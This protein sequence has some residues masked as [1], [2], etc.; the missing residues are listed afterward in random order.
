MEAFP[1]KLCVMP[2]HAKNPGRP[3]FFPIARLAMALLWALS[4]RSAAGQ[5]ITN[6]DQ[7]TRV[8]ASEHRAHRSLQ[9]EVTVC[10]ASRPKVGVLIVQ[11]KTGVELLAVGNFEREILPGEKILI[12]GEYDLLRQREMGVELA[13]AP[14]VD[15]DG[16][17]IRRTLVAST[18]LKA[19]LIPLRLDWF[20]GLR[21]FNLEVACV[22]SN[23]LG[24]NI[25]AS[26]LWHA[27]V[28][29][30]G[31]TNFSP[32]LLAE[33]YEGYWEAVPD[34][35]LLQPV[36]RGVVSNFD[37]GFKPRD[38][39]VGVRFTGC[40]N[41]PQDGQYKF[42]VR[43]KDGSLLFLNAPE[44][45]PVRLGA[46]DVPVPRAGFYGERM[47]HLNERW[48]TTI[49]GRVGFV[50]K[51]GEGIEFDLHSDRDVISIQVTDA[52]G[53][54]PARLR[55]SRVKV[56]GIGHAALT[57]DQRLVLGKIFAASAKEIQLIQNA[58]GN[59]PS[60][61]ITSVG[62]VQS[63]P[64]ED[65]R[66]ALPVRLRGVVT[67]AKNSTYD[68]WMSLQDDTR[69]IFVSLTAVSNSLPA[70]GESWEVT[71]HSGAGDFAPVVIADKLTSLGEGRLPEPVRPTWTELL[72]GSMD[73]QW[74]EL[75]GLVTDVESNKVTLLLPEGRLDV[76][77]AGHFESELK[78]FQNTVARIRGVLYAM[79]NAKTREVLV[80]N[81]M[82]RNAT[83]SADT[84]A[85]ADPFDAVLKT[86]RELLLFDEQATP[87]RCVKV[88]GQVIYA[89]AT[90]IFFE[91]DGAGLRLSPAN[92]KTDV[93]P[94]DVVD[95]VG[96]PDI[97]RKTLLLREVQ[98]RKTGV[99]VLPAAQK[100]AESELM[101]EGLD[102]TRVRVDG[103]LLGWH[104]ERGAPVLEMQSG[105]HL[106]LAR[107]SPRN[108]V[109]VSLRTGSRLALEG[110]YVASGRSPQPGAEA[111]SFELL[112][113]SPAD[114]TVLSQ[115]P[116]WT[117]QKLLILIGVLLAVLVFTLV[118][119][120]QL[121]RQVEQR[122]AQLR[123]ETRERER[124]EHRHALEAERS[125]IA[126][127]LHDDLGSSLTEISVLASTGQRPPTADTSHAN[128]FRGI[129]SKAR[130]LIAALDVIVWAVDPEDNSLQSLADYLSGYTEEF[131]SNTNLSC[132]FKVPVAFPQITLEGRVRHDL[133]L[134][135]KETLNNIVRH[136]EATEVEFRMASA[137]GNLEIEIADN[138]KGFVGV[139]QPEGHGLKNL[140]AR[141]KNIGGDCAIE[142]RVGGGTTVKIRLP[143]A[144]DVKAGQN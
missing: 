117:L 140:P 142:S 101:R 99:A 12:Q 98:L 72:N 130:G 132:R 144:G 134:A 138:G 25:I 133:L 77:V 32:G 115:P 112:L 33:S 57:A 42:S 105:T 29:D 108:A 53:L 73:V 45:R 13:A 59:E 14:L 21:D 89:D 93:R 43:S 10:A 62:Q 143:L 129:A 111:G 86:P 23:G 96:Y 106:Y 90:Q 71:G 19:G 121:R 16:M 85:P 125:R 34:F 7:L 36:K 20:N 3:V 51:K 79:W 104:L 65:A 92:N 131:F 127:D 31:R 107:L 63:L 50:S 139:P 110:V 44:L 22:S 81:V 118:W 95:V 15:N 113:N 75:H 137:D 97:G 17:H 94:G 103:K 61:P 116:W 38:E 76:L 8:V 41:I 122:T 136:A 54:D 88:H 27:V 87:F 55:N 109:E 47:K 40:L 28:D 120:T 128:L 26:N 67:D 66:R 49:E 123:R 135:V 91:A 48:W 30:L 11:D 83:I 58:S 24:K 70:F 124:V 68:R 119:I 82:M 6:L 2:D 69:G 9:L 74:A 56:T 35:E 1:H 102:S 4:V 141:L 64:I 18:A 60:P 80:G 39:M 114:I 5:T 84:A 100:L 52:D 37:L 126:R 78:P 46:A